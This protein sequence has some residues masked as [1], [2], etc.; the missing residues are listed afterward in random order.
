[1]K[2]SSLCVSCFSH[3]RRFAQTPNLAP[4]ARR[5]TA[6]ETQWCVLPIGKKLRKVIWSTP[7]TAAIFQFP[8]ASLL[9]LHLYRKP[10]VPKAPESKVGTKTAV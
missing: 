8:R 10:V 9:G 3:R 4:R 2:E 5:S 1:M 6:L 7:W